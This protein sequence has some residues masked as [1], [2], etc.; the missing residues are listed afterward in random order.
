M[1]VLVCPRFSPLSSQYSFGSAPATL[2]LSAPHTRAVL[3]ITSS[4]PSLLVFQQTDHSHV[5]RHLPVEQQAVPM[6]PFDAQVTGLAHD[7]SCKS[8]LLTPKLHFDSL[9]PF[10]LQL[11]FFHLPSQTPAAQASVAMVESCSSTSRL[12]TSISQGKRNRI[13]IFLLLPPFGSS[14]STILWARCPRLLISHAL[15]R[16]PNPSS[17]AF[18]HQFSCIFADR[19]DFS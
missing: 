4:R 17:T 2:L 14:I 11:L 7:G 10:S 6:R 16:E 15:S 8:S 13:H 18:S 12:F 19:H 3:S 1:S 5:Q 9:F